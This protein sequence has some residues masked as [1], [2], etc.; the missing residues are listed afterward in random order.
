MN[1]RIVVIATIMFLMFAPMAMAC[2]IEAQCEGPCGKVIQPGQQS[3]VTVS[4]SQSES[5]AQGQQ[6]TLALTGDERDF[7]PSPVVIPIQPV[8]MQGGSQENYT[9]YLPKF[10]DPMLQPFNFSTDVVVKQLDIFNGKWLFGL[11]GNITQDELWGKLLSLPGNYKSYPQDKIRIQVQVSSSSV[12]NGIGGGGSG[13]SSVMNAS[14][15]V[16]GSAS[17]LPHHTRWTK[18]D[19]FLIRVLLIQ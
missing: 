17:I 7:L 3:P 10:A 14:N 16:S 1:K 4:Q 8:P 15:A 9:P 6:F 12:E 5:L 13:G 11:F 19:T 18:D 2:D